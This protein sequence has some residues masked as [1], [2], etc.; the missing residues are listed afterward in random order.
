M[1]KRLAIAAVIAAAA[2]AL[3]R[4]T[5]PAPTSPTVVA[6]SVAPAPAAAYVAGP[7]CVA[8]LG[9]DDLRRVRDEVVA[10]GTP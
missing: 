6:A 7:P 8:R 9:D 2:F 1:T 4:A 5:A 10:A 3:G